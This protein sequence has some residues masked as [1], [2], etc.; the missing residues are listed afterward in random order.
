[1]RIDDEEDAKDD[2]EKEEDE[3]K[4]DIFPQTRPW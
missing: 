1:M 2:L 4:T 3:A